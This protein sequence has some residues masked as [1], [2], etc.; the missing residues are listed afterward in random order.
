MIGRRLLGIAAALFVIIVSLYGGYQLAEA[1]HL[2][3]YGYQTSELERGLTERGYTGSHYRRWRDPDLDEIRQT[4]E[5]TKS[6][7]ATIHQE[8][9]RA[10][11]FVGPHDVCWSDDQ[12]PLDDLIR[13]GNAAIAKSQEPP[14]IQWTD[15]PATSTSTFDIPLGGG[16]KMHFICD[17]HEAK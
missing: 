9:G 6:G 1:L 3:P 5:W 10:A 17:H 15:D 16:L 2:K 13:A 14:F 8:N 12:P 4:S 7:S 11:K